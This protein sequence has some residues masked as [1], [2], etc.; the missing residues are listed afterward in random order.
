MLRK[1]D[2]R[3]MCQRPRQA[4]AVPCFE[5]ARTWLTA[6]PPRLEALVSRSLSLSKLKTLR[7]TTWQARIMLSAFTSLPE[8]ARLSVL[9][10]EA[11]RL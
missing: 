6:P 4:R 1:L 8:L 11:T 3:L 10:P 2:R 9:K 5:L 7:V